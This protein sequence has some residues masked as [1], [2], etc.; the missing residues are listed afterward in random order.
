MAKLVNWHDF[1]AKI[2]GKKIPMFSSL[3][4]RRLFGVSKIAADF[5]LYRYHKK[6]YITRIKRGLYTFPDVS[7]SE[8]FIACKLCEPSYI[9]LETA[10]SYWGVIPETVYEITSIT[11]KTTN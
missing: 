2:K 3:D 9:S 10:L 7:V 8:L 11:P 5:L 6:K 4:V 1:A